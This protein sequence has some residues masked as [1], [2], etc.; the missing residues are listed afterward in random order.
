MDS[1]VIP[2]KITYN[3]NDQGE[4][5]IVITVNGHTLAKED[6]TPEIPAVED[7]C[8]VLHGASTVDMASRVAIGKIVKDGNSFSATLGKY[9]GPNPLDTVP[10]GTIN[11][12]PAGAGAIQLAAV[13]LKGLGK[14]LNQAGI[15]IHSGTDCTGGADKNSQ[16]AVNKVVGGHLLSR[17]DGFA[18]TTY[19]SSRLTTGSI[20]ISTP[21]GAYV[22]FSKN[23]NANLPAVEGRC[24][25]LHNPDA[26][27]TRVGVG[28]IVCDNGG[29]CKAT[30]GP[31]PTTK[32]TTTTKPTTPAPTPAPMTT[33][34]E[35]PTTA[36][37]VVVSDNSGAV[38]KMFVSLSA[39]LVSCFASF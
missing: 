20:D 39:L 24:I 16:D 18:T 19:T 26:A 11:L 38:A 4:A 28:K 29:S 22:L 12:T 2:K 3:T 6:G 32:K 5:S 23:G 13:N 8:I 7:H 14:G 21:K 17:A 15:H 1:W 10:S 31:Y 9:P 30:I 25:V 27:K 34:T 37:N 33:T 35:A 36:R